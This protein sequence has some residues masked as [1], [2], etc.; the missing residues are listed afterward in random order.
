MLLRNLLKIIKSNNFKLME[1]TMKEEIL[2]HLDDAKDLE[3]LY[4]SNGSL[5]K[6][7]FMAIYSEIGESPIAK[8]WYERLTYESELISKGNKKELL[9]VVLL[10]LVAGLIV[11]LNA[12]LGIDEE[13]YYSRN[14]GFVVFPVL[15]AY[16]AWINRLSLKKIIISGSFFVLL[17]VFINLL[18]NNQSDTVILACI[19][20]PLLLWALLGVAFVADVEDRNT[21][22]LAYLK[23][24]GDLVVMSTLLI[25]AGMILSLVTIGLFELLGM[26]IEDFYMGNIGR[27]GFAITPIVATYLIQK[28]PQ[29]VGRISPVIARI[30]SP[31]VL[32][33]LVVYLVAIVYSG[34]DP[35]NDRAFL[36]IFNA[37]LIGVLAVIYF[38]VSESSGNPVNKLRIWILFLLSAVTI[39]VNG[40]ALSAILFR[41][42]EWGLTPNRTA[43]LG[44][45]TLV[46]VNLILVAVQLIKVIS[47]KSNIDRIGIVISRYLPVYII[48]AAIVTFVFPLLSQLGIGF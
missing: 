37:L 11:K 21:R 26:N 24:N 16:F 9:V 30:F 13:F 2:K 10:A 29:L 35:Y 14:I 1:S 41:I 32:I 15:F 38:S 28:N 7:E 22:S 25:I 45:N 5:F 18:P 42:S 4:R 48:W 34:K 33:M 43:V 27:V 46:L 44:A 20:M 17:A 36:L 8:S 31:L 19:H 23:Y 3:R 6:R 39:I 40:I 12:I 47:G